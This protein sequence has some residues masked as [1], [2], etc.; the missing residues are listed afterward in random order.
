MPLKREK[1][2]EK[3]EKPKSNEGPQFRRRVF[4][5]KKLLSVVWGRVEDE[6]VR[7]QQ[8]VMNNRTTILLKEKI[9]RKV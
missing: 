8:R 3:R 6:R 2:K 9:G 7:D 5:P 1:R 4:Y